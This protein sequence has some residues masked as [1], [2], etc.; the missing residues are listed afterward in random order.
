MCRRQRGQSGFVGVGSLGKSRRWTESPQTQLPVR[1][2]G[3][4]GRSP[5]AESEAYG[6]SS[7]PPTIQTTGGPYFLSLVEMLQDLSETPIE[8]LIGGPVLYVYF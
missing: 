3:R 8:F 1:R 7:S 6:S 5:P 4:N 2:S